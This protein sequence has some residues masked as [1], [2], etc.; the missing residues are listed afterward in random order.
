M[1]DA[2]DKMFCP[3]QHILGLIF[4][5]L[6]SINTTTLAQTFTTCTFI[7]HQCGSSGEN[8]VVRLEVVEEDSR[9]RTIAALQQIAKIVIPDLV[10]TIHLCGR[11]NTGN[12]TEVEF[13]VTSFVSGTVT[14]EAVWDDL[15]DPQQVRIVKELL[16]SVN[17]LHALN[18]SDGTM[19]KHLEGTGFVISGSESGG[20]LVV[21]GPSTGYFSDIQRFFESIIETHNPANKKRTSY[22]TADG[23]ITIHSEY[24]DLSSVHIPYDEL[25]RLQQSIVLCHQ[26]LEPRNILVHPHLS[27]DGSTEYQIAAIIDWEMSG[28]FPFSYEYVAKDFF[29]GNSNLYFS[30]YALFKEHAAPMIPMALQ[31]RCHALFMEAI[32]LIHYS[33]ERE[34]RTVPA[35]VTKKWLAREGVVRKEPAGTGWVK[36]AGS[37]RSKR[38]SPAEMDILEKEALR[39][40]GRI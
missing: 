33:R 39:D 11:G 23:G 32:N 22:L 27:R 7:A 21:G 16:Y 3:D 10:P 6:Q 12:G 30:W 38:L 34:R 19:R 28:F 35:L 18:I 13:S 20:A 40:L 31:P 1:S 25:Q 2:D 9:F 15:P 36:Q 5:G 29:L 24:D 17:K 4:P 37:P 26:D 14:L 8:V